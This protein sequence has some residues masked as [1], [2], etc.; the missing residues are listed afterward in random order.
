MAHAASTAPPLL[1]AALGPAGTVLWGSLTGRVLL[2]RLAG[3]SPPGAQPAALAGLEDAL[4]LARWETSPHLSALKVERLLR[5][6]WGAPVKTVLDDLELSAPVASTPF[7]QV[8]RGWLGGA[9]LAV[10]VRRPGVE[11]MTRADQAFLDAAGVSLGIRAASRAASSVLAHLLEAL[12]FEHEAEQRRLFAR[13]LRATPGVVVPPAMPELSTLDVLVSGWLEG[14]T[15]AAAPPPDAAATARALVAAHLAAARAG[16]LLTD[17]RP[18]HVV[19]LDGG[20]VGIVGLGVVPVEPARL[21]DRLVLL[22]TL[23]DAGPDRFAAAAWNLLGDAGA[24][25]ALHSL[26]RAV[27]GELVQGA[28]LLDA[29]TLAAVLERA[30]AYQR[31]A[32]ALA[33]VCTPAP[34]D[35]A[36]AWS[37]ARLVAVLAALGAR[38]DWLALAASAQC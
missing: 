13:A 23:R 32:R 6:A 20:A 4:V 19:A 5:A 24:A 36:L 27:L 30:L 1:R 16:L 35:L 22:S 33:A 9:P 3:T 14:P 11:A 18:N 28:A 8:H 7:A 38:E 31:E 34:G 17:A 26:L 15:L 37:G 21:E 2:G 25:R 29:A 10:K 12:D